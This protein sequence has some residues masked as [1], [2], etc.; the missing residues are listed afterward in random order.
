M[1]K[2]ADFIEELEVS[3]SSQSDPIKVAIIDDGV[4]SSH[5][6]LDANIDEGESWVRQAKQRDPYSPYNTSAKGH[7]TVMAYY[8]RRVCPK[9]RLYVAKLD[10]RMVQGRLV[11]SMES[12]AEV[13]PSNLGSMS[14]SIV[15]G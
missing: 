7:G 13:N 4:K 5:A 15:S 2:F 8:I 6:G 3:E 12:A 14:W 10:P 11:F 9:V 1:D